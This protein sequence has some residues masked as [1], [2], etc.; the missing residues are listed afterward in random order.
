MQDPQTCDIVPFGKYKGRPVV[1]LIADRDYTDWL[2]AQPWFRERYQTVYNLIVNTG[3][4]PQDTPEHNK[5]QARYLDHDA[6][7]NL[8]S[9]WLQ[10]PSDLG[11]TWQEKRAA[12]LTDRQRERLRV[13]V[14]RTSITSLQFESHGWD[15]VTS[16]WSH[17]PVTELS[18]PTC[19]CHCEPGRCKVR[20]TDWRRDAPLCEVTDDP[21]DWSECFDY[22]AGSDRSR[23]CAEDCPVTWKEA[24]PVAAQRHPR[25]RGIWSYGSRTSPY[26]LALEDVDDTVT[27]AIELKPVLGDDYPSVLRAVLKR[28]EMNR[29][30]RVVDAD[31]LVVLADEVQFEGVDLA[32]VRK[33]FRSQRVHLLTTAELPAPSPDW[34]C[35]CKDCTAP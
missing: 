29:A 35:T 2:A 18:P 26:V 16:G 13:G 17:L 30:R 32:A 27:A 7:L 4:Q 6:C 33:M 10:S 22:G 20:K 23:H 19:E 3:T 5:M 25:P 9:V 8:L 14:G 34:H 1:D 15:L 11:K 21:R 28:A 24:V 31:V 12:K